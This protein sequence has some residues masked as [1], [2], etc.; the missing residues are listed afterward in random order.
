MFNETV[1]VF[2]MNYFVLIKK[3]FVAP[4]PKTFSQNP[5][6]PALKTPF[7]ERGVTKS[8]LPAW[9]RLPSLELPEVRPGFC[10]DGDLLCWSQVILLMGGTN[11]IQETKRCVF[12]LLG[13]TGEQNYYFLLIP[14]LASLTP[15]RDYGPGLTSLCCHIQL[16]AEASS[17]ALD[18]PKIRF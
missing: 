2:K 5:F 12:P 7:A 11:S 15:C 16:W 17:P 1:S 4:I 8:C 14:I 9:I 13:N 6:K 18:E 10:G 3:P